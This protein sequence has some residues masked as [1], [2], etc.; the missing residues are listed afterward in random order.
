MSYE[1]KVFTIPKLRL[2]ILKFLINPITCLKCGYLPKKITNMNRYKV[3]ICEWCDPYGWKWRPNST[4][5]IFLK[6]I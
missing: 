6:C 2:N 5:N 4:N 1:I 3:Y